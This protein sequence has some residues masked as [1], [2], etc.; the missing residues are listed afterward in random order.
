MALPFTISAA[1]SECS[2][3]SM[4]SSASRV[5]SVLDFDLSDGCLTIS[6]CYFNLQ[7]PNDIYWEASF[8]VLICHLSFFISELLFY[9]FFNRVVHFLILTFRSSLY[10]LYNIPLSNNLLQIFSPICGLS[11]Y[12][13]GSVFHRAVF[14][15]S[16]STLS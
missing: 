12:S 11:S 16:L 6:C 2:C 7:F 5:A 13:L 3:W 1:I 9:P 4:F 14:K 10:M 8:H 15:F